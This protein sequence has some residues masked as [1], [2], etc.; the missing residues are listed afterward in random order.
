MKELLSEVSTTLKLLGY[1]K[2]GNSF[3][4][5]D[6]NIYKLIDF[7]KG[8]HGG[9]YFFVNV[10]VHP[11]GLPK[12]ITSEISICEHPKNHECV[13]RQRIEQISQN[14]QIKLFQR[15][16]VSIDN[17]EVIKAIIDTIP[18]EVELWLEEWGTYEK[19]ANSEFNEISHMMTVVP[20]LKEKAFLMLKFY[21]NL[22]LGD[23]KKA[24]QYLDQY[25]N[26]RIIGLEFSEVDSYLK[27]LLKL[28]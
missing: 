10:C 26:T 28:Q 7:Q 1:R 22:K 9:G 8:A 6:N 17:R 24:E 3:W 4:K 20:K 11:I 25:L 19:F 13:L 23:N 15:G 27:S 14:E 21:S 16:L 12:L 18:L 5:I 2:K